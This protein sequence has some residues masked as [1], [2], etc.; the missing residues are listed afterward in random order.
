MELTRRVRLA[1]GLGGFLPALLMLCALFAALAA[2]LPAPPGEGMWNLDLPKIDVPLAVFFHEALAEGRLPLWN[3]RL[4]LGFPLY[5][6]GQIGA[7]YPPNWLIYQLEP[8]AALDVARWTHL[9]VAGTGAG[10]LALRLAG[11]R[12]GAVVAAAVTILGGAIVTKLEWT[13]LVAAYA[14]LPWILLPLARRPQPTRRG[15]VAAALLYGLQA[16]AGHPNTW[17]LTGVTVL[18]LL[19]ASQ[20]GL[21]AVGRA[22]FV[23]VVGGAV[24]AAQLV[25]TLLLQQLSVRSEGLS[26]N[27]VFTS[28]ATVFDPLAFAFAHPFV[29]TTVDGWD[30]FSG[31]YPDGSFALLEASA[32]VGLAVLGLGAVG[33]GTRRARPWLVVGAVLLAIPVIAAFRPEPWLGIP[34]LNG[35]R[36]PVRSY[37]IVAMILGL[38][39]AIGVGRLGRWWSRDGEGAAR[40]RRR[41]ALVVAASAA[42]LGIVTLAAAYDWRLWEILIR[43]AANTLR[44]EDVERLQGLAAAALTQ[45][46]PIAGEVV[47]GA[48]VLACIVLAT[49]HPWPGERRLAVAILAV[50]PLALLSPAANPMRPQSEA[51][52]RDSELAVALRGIQPNRILT[53]DRPGFYAGAPDRLAAA[54]V[55]DLEMFSS[56]DLAATTDLLELARHAEDAE[57]IRRLIG[58]D[59][60]VTFGAECPGTDPVRL[61]P[62]E[63]V[64]CRV[65]ALVGP[66]WIPADAVPA[67][68]GDEASLDI[69][70][71]LAGAMPVAHTGSTPTA[72]DV[73]VDAPADGYVW[74]DRAWWPSWQVAVDGTDVR[75]SRALA[76]MLVP[77]AAGARTITLRLVPLEALA[78]AAVGAVVALLALVWAGVGRSV[79]DRRRGVSPSARRRP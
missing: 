7:F 9:V 29:R 30:Y 67:V 15:L 32:F 12:S 35:L 5:A 69:D 24:G 36:S 57:T 6:E 3:D 21:V 11:S 1:P 25:P 23:G 16:L 40:A 42:W 73:T 13:N 64:I 78:G 77:V 47:L 44:A 49:R 48:V 37:L 66:Y 43:S 10:L 54:G 60:L 56:L 20:P 68:A 4:G 8:L 31:W 19:L 18:V 75:P 17:L 33:A 45:P 39:A 50:L 41:A 27:D 63:A 76:G 72:L 51:W 70:R 65:P 62:D 59:T 53:L 55:P 38:L 22:A 79:L 14:W 52:L 28:S 26:P 46:W 58:I 34:I 74:V 61:V 2:R 71:A